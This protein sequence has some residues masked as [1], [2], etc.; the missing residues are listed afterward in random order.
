MSWNQKSHWVISPAAYAVRGAGSGCRYE[1]RLSLVSAQTR[2]ERV[3]AAMTLA[4][5]SEVLQPTLGVSD[6]WLRPLQAVRVGPP[7][8]VTASSQRSNASRLP[9]KASE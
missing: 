8:G 9:F 1:L 7:G 6:S 2:S 5:V 3:L 4:V